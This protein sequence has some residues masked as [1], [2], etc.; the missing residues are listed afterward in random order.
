MLVPRIILGFE[1]YVL[2]A[3]VSWRGRGVGDDLSHRYVLQWLNRCVV[4]KSFILWSIS[5]LQCS[6]INLRR[7]LV[8]FKGLM[9]NPKSFQEQND[10][11]AEVRA[12]GQGDPDYESKFDS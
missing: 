1:N 11:H 4:C 3:R 8:C 5:T 2:A 10:E 9:F 12:Q 6:Y 7:L